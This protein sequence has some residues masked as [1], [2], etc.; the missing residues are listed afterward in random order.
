MTEAEEFGARLTLLRRNRGM[1]Q[2]DLG[3]ILG[4]SKGAVSNFEKGRNYPLPD[5]L[6]KLA[7]YFGVTVD[8]LLTGPGLEYYDNTASATN[9]QD[10]SKTISDLRRANN[11]LQQENLRLQH[12]LSQRDTVLL[13]PSQWAEF[14]V[15][16]PR[17]VEE[18]VD[19]AWSTKFEITRVAAEEQMAVY[20]VGRKPDP[21][22]PFSGLLSKRLGITET[23]AKN[24]VLSGRIGAIDTGDSNRITDFRIPESSVQRF[25]KTGNE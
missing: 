14:K 15:L 2:E 4:I 7:R 11:V 1:S 6:V 24:L 5:K 13:D 20:W 17:L 18:R 12:A 21:A 10:Q 19:D 22:R 8:F 23:E 3:D 9:D 25:L 16:L